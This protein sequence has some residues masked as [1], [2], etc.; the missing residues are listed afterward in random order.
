MEHAAHQLAPLATQA[1]SYLWLIPLFP[2]V[3]AFINASMGLRLQRRFGKG[4]VHGISIGAMVLSFAVACV[5]FASLLGLDGE[6]RFLQDT[7][8]NVFTAGKVSVDLGFAL[9]PLSMMMTLMITFVGTL[10]HVFSTGYMADEPSYWRFFAYLNLF[11]FSMLLLVMGDNFVLMFFGWE[12]VGLCSYLL[13]AFWYTDAQ[14]AA[15][16]MKAFVTNRFG[17]FGFVLGVFL[18]FWALGG[19]W[20]KGADGKTAYVETDAHAAAYLAAARGEEHGTPHVEVGPTLNFRQLRDQ[21]V[22]PDTGVAENLKHQKIFGLGLLAMVGILLFVGAMGKSAQLPLH[23]WLPDAM[24]GPTP[25]SALIHAATMVTAGVYMVARLNF[26]FALSPTAMGWV[27]FIGALT[28]L[29]AASIGFFQYDI[30]KVLAY[31][32]VSQLGF[33]FIG[34]G[35]GAYWAGAYHL[36]TH[37]FFKATLFLGSGSVILGCHHEQDMRNMGGLGKHMPVTRLTYL[38]AC[39]AIAGFPWASGFYSKDEILWKAFTQEGMDFLG[40]PAPWLGPLIY[41]VGIV[42]AVGTSYYMFRSYYMTFTGE[43]RGHGHGHDEGHGHGHAPHE[44][45]LSIT[46]VLVAL[47]AGAVLAAILGIPA[48]WSGSAPILKRWLEPSLP[49]VVSFAEKSHATEYLFQAIGVSA[50]VIGWVFARMLYKDGKSEVPARLLQRWKRAWTVVYN[51][52]YVDELYQATILRGAVAL[53]RL[54]SWFDKHIIDGIVNLAGAIT[55]VFAN[56]DGAIDRYLVDGAVNLVADSALSAGS[57][58]RRVQTGRI[59]TY[60][61]GALVGAVAIVLLNFLIK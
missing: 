27:A 61:Y 14:K 28:A 50:G 4:L 23:V 32:T 30:K 49:A 8:W 36:L 15:A 43:Y 39:W 52:Y 29:F 13:I 53:A 33:M 58:L 57:I 54:L 46:L 44:S 9:D 16:G 10:I 35:V 17:D 2:L 47:A 11:V 20:Q 19:A 48:A 18:L 55:R 59:Q 21:I 37:A 60:L 7:L 45:P 26:V 25:V 56:I 38:V 12:G 51:K 34:V 3:G 24:A 31:S 40:F 41:V 6:H 22:I 42:A 1:A 5:A